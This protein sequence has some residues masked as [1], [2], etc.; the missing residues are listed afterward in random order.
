M[1]LYI[2]TTVNPVIGV[3][4]W[5]RCLR[6]A[7]IYQNYFNEIVFVLRK[8]D[9]PIF[10]I[11]YRIILLE[12]P[13]EYLYSNVNKTDFII[14]DDY[15]TSK[16]EIICLN[17]H[18]TIEIND[19]PQNAKYC[20]YLINQTPFITRDYFDSHLKSECFLGANYLLV[21]KEFLEVINKHGADKLRTGFVFSFGG[22]DN[23]KTGL[24]YMREA[25]ELISEPIHLI[26][27]NLNPAINELKDL[28][29]K[30]ENLQIHIDINSNKI[31]E[32]LLQ[33]K[34]CVTTASTFALE[35]ICCGPF[36]ICGL[37]QDNQQ[38][39]AKNLAEND[40][41]L[42]VGTFT[43]TNLI[44]IIQLINNSSIENQFEKRQHLL[45]EIGTSKLLE[46][47]KL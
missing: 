17:K 3:G 38:L 1:N 10:E 5:Y 7:E 34:F 41:A 37:T 40:I 23:L 33:A 2:Q 45:S 32:L 47:I 8:G 26:T 6:L 29:M 46:I 42:N 4:H 9:I 43:E 12:N 39:I 30:N 16:D 22:T 25:V 35:A 20:K 21:R 36:L 14:I 19:I 27:T 11:P 31:I 24:N 15:K 44:E 28:A 13:I 18:N